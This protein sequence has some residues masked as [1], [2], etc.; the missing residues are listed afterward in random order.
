MI[1]IINDLVFVISV[2]IR[3][4]ILCWVLAEKDDNTVLHPKIQIEIMDYKL[5]YEV[6]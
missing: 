1:F 2:F 6:D 5:N 4:I 3:G